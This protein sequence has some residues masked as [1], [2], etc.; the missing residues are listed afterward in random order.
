MKRAIVLFTISLIALTIGFT[1]AS[2]TNVVKLPYKAYYHFMSAD[3]KQEI[4]CLA[5]NIYFE[6]ALE[7][8]KGQVA[9]AFVTI[10]R[11]KSGF[12]E[13]DICGV[14]KQKIN[15]T[16]QFSWWCE[17]R[18]KAIYASNVLTNGQN[19]LYNDIRNLAVHVYANYDKIEDPSKGALFY[20][21]DYVRP[22]WRNMEHLT[23]I[24][25]H[26]FYNRRDMKWTS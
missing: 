8:E 16:C 3:A 25:R 12:F 5:K 2:V 14:V 15:G 11:V 17:E 6:A 24:G 18:P 22:G 9:V 19:M 10:N 21:A 13:N 7:P 4:E 23:T 1:I 20:H 26:I